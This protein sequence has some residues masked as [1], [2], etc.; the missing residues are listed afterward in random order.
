MP[1]PTE[2]RGNKFWLIAQCC[3]LESELC[4]QNKSGNVSIASRD[5]PYHKAQDV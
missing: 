1:V 3:Q 5:N 4:R 2:R